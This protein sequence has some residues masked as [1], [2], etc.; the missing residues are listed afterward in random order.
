VVSNTP[1][2]VRELAQQVVNKVTGDPT[3]DTLIKIGQTN[4]TAMSELGDLVPELMRLTDK[5]LDVNKLKGQSVREVLVMLHDQAKGNDKATVA[6]AQKL[7]A[8]LP[9]LNDLPFEE[10]Y[11]RVSVKK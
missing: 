6:Q 5:I 11:L 9:I 8:E 3:G 1:Q 10:L 4:G 2:P 7:L